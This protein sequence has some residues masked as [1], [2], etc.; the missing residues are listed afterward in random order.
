VK[1]KHFAINLLANTNTMFPKKT[2]LSES[3]LMSLQTRKKCC[4]LGL[5]KRETAKNCRNN[6]MQYISSAGRLVD[7]KTAPNG[8]RNT[9]L[10]YLI[11][12]TFYVKAGITRSLI[13][14]L[15]RVC[16]CLQAGC[17]LEIEEKHSLFQHYYNSLSYE[18]KTILL[19]AM[20]EVTPTN[21]HRSD[22]CL[23]K[24]K[25]L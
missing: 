22:F 17:Q 13:L 3:E 14:V 12:C 9:N 24:L 2:I 11:S 10:Q 1:S 7:A 8:V 15:Q 25:I 5:R 23:S 6:G 21:R 18:S 16:Q 19:S 20:I 4:Y